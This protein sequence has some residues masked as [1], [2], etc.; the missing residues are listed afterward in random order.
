M[1]YTI[2]NNN[3]HLV[4]SCE[5]SKHN[6][7]RNLDEIEAEAPRFDVWNR[8]RFSMETEW[9]VHNALYDCHIARE[10]TAS[11]DLNYPQPWYIRI[12]YTVV[13]CIVWPFIR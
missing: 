5:V 7:R 13:G 2:T 3:L 4:D 11:C 1:D 9:A 10:R 8:S 12:A 6:F